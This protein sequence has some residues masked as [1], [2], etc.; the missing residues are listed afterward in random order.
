MRQRLAEGTLY[1]MKEPN[2]DPARSPWL[3]P[4]FQFEGGGLLPGVREVAPEFD[5]ALSPV[6][7]GR[8][9]TA[10]NDELVPADE[11]DEGEE[12]VSPREWLLRGLS[13]SRVA[14]LARY[15]GQVL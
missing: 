10:A 3:V 11:G 5:R 1:G 9:F 7:V 8:W 2:A 12:P 13:S 6:T 15:L 4:A 14:L